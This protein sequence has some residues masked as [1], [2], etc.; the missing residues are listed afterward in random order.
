MS[1]GFIS[2]FLSHIGMHIYSYDCYYVLLLCKIIY[3]YLEVRDIFVEG[4]RKGNNG[5]EYS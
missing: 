2:Q 3:D 1:F 4:Q 5:C